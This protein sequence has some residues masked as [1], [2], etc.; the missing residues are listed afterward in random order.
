MADVAPHRASSESLRRAIVLDIDNDIFAAQI[1]QLTEYA[2]FF[3]DA[4]GVIRS[5]NQGVER[6]FGYSAAEWIGQHASIIFTPADR[7]I[8][9]S[10]AEFGIAREKGCASD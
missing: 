2:F 1:T 5:W 10:E 9:L 8:A 6:L 4:D 3:I 7:A